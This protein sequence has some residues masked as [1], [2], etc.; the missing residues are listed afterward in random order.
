MIELVW[1]PRAIADLE[2]IRAYIAT[3]SPAW[4][5]LTVRRLVASVERLREYPDSGRMVPERQSA[6]LREVVSGKFRIV[7]RRKPDLVEIATV[8]RGSRDFPIAE[9]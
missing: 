7:Y 8:F 3:D 2:E 6:E 5:D 1:S 9:V 4:A